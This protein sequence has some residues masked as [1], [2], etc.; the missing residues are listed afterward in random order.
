VI[1]PV[2]DRWI[3]I[4]QSEGATQL[5]QLPQPASQPKRAESPGLLA[6]IVGVLILIGAGLAFWIWKR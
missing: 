6:A 1:F 3:E 2:G 4:S 5:D